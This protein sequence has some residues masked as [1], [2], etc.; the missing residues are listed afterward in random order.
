MQQA[1]PRTTAVQRAKL[2]TVTEKT[3]GWK[4]ERK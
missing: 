3:A 4:L 1:K 2:G